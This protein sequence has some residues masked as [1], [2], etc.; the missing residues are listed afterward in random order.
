MIPHSIMWIVT[1]ASL[2][3]VV[4]NIHHRRWCFHVWAA[5]NA[6]WAGYDLSLG[7]HAQAALQATFIGR[8][9]F[10]RYAIQGGALGFLKDD[11]LIAVVLVN[12]RI[13]S[14]QV[15]CVSPQCRRT[16]I[17]SLIVQFANTNWAR[18]IESSEPFFIKN[19]YQRIGEPKKGRRFNTFI[20]VR[21]SLIG[22]AGRLKRN[23]K[24]V[25]HATTQT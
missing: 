10:R 20:M 9:Q 8:N 4:A 22:L 14:L 12:P 19:G 13:N 17:G 11:Q 1:L 2:I 23:G 3:G 25:I 18:V 5:T 24:G 7:A 21:S 16:G 6:A 15:L